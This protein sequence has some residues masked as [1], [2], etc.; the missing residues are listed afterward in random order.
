MI[1]G[2]R[3][4]TELDRENILRGLADGQVYGGPYHLELDWVDRCNA[5]CFFCNSE[6]IHKGESIPWERARVL[7]EEAAAG[8]LRSI[9]LSGGGEPTLHPNFP[10]LVELLAARNIV[11]DNLTTNGTALIDRAIE[12]LLR[13]RVH[14]IRVS[15]N[16]PTAA[17]WSAGMGLHE[18]L[19]EKAVDSVRKLSRARRAIPGF[20]RLMIQFFI[21]KPTIGLIEQ[22][23][24]LARELDVDL[25]TYRELID[26]DPALQLAPGDAPEVVERMSRVLREDWRVGIVENHLTSHGLGERFRVIYD[27][28]R[29]ELGGEPPMAPHPVNHAIRYCYMPWYSMTLLGSQAAYPCC[30]LMLHPYLP[31]LGSV[32]EHSLGE[33]WRGEAFARLRKEMREF[34]LLQERGP[35]FLRRMKQS[36]P[37]CA[38]HTECSLTTSLADEAFYEEAER[39]LALERRRPVVRLERLAAK[40]ALAVERHLPKKK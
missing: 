8:G 1:H 10:D 16:Y 28:L 33:I 21:Y 29:A 37:G 38:S 40:A 18:R 2:W 30:F 20:G 23:Y 12:A 36:S 14:E 9:R 3:H 4:L 31:S 22:S 17:T 7:L 6:S 32:A 27:A 13:A 39:R 24:A 35:F 26:I 15:L 5:R 25:V 19:F 11:L 34:F